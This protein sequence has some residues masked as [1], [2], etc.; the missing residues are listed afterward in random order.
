[1]NEENTWNVF[2]KKV[3]YKQ[4]MCF[5]FP[6][7]ANKWLI[8]CNVDPGS[9]LLWWCRNTTN[10]HIRHTLAVAN[11]PS[12]P[13][14]LM[15][16]YL[17]LFSK[18]QGAWQTPHIPNQSG[19]YRMC[20]NKRQHATPRMQSICYQSPS[21]RYHRTPTEVLY[22]CFDRS[23]KDLHE[24]SEIYDDWIWMLVFVGLDI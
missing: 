7:I 13:R 12:S 22:P 8:N 5:F 11:F 18:V 6:H 16:N 3:L 14:E 2:Q 23:E 4:G 21:A 9:T 20:H 17:E 15:K 24:I 19:I 1:M 10:G